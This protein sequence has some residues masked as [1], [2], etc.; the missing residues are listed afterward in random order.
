MAP[1]LLCRWRSNVLWLCSRL[2]LFLLCLRWLLR[3]SAGG[4]VM[5]WLCSRLSLF[6]LCLRWLLRWLCRWRS[7]VL[8]LS[9]R[10]SLF[11]LCLRWLLRWLCQWRVCPLALQQAVAVPPLLAMAPALALP[12]ARCVLWLCSRLS[13]FLLCP[14]ALRWLCRWRGNVLWLCSGMS[15][16]LLCCDGS[17]WLCDGAVMSSGSAGCRC[18]SSACDGSCA[19]S[20]GGACVL[21]L[22]S[23]MLFF[24]CAMAPAMVPRLMAL[25]GC[26][27]LAR[28]RWL[29]G[30]FLR[31][32]GR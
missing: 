7:N 9:S 16:F 23:G 17:A 19:G 22:C 28:C 8:W 6:L 14:L 12:V 32:V 31:L 24:L 2:S 18:S 20:A 30:W 10:L 11:L 4:A 29:L 15:L 1:A 13:L 26:R 21:W 27:R 3:C 5:S 25:P